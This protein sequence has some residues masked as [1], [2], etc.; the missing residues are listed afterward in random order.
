MKPNF[1]GAL[2]YPLRGFTYLANHRELWKY[3]AG[4][5]L[6]NLAAFA[7]MAVVF[8]LNLS[9]FVDALRPS[10]TPAWLVPVIGCF[11]TLVAAL[12]AIFLFTIVGN[13]VAGPFMDALC[14]KM[15]KD[16]GEALPPGRGFA[17]AL[18]R[19]IVNQGFKLAIFGSCQI[20]LLLLLLTPL[21]ILYPVV[22]GALTVLFLAFEYVDFPLDARRLSVPAR[23]G[24]LTRHP[25]PSLGFGAALFGI[26][27]VPFLG[28]LALPFAV[29]GATLLVHDL[30]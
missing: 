25:G 30:K 10:S 11:L 19:S 17:N 22:A 26:C 13:V 9:G 4:A 18:V 14:E 6:A 16:L 21:G 7:I 20:P 24:Y 1:L 29:C 23:F 2:G 5:F 27:L 12:V 8:F 3:A 15:L 28:Y